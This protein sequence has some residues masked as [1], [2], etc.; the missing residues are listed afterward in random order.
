MF[1][2]TNPAH[3][4]EPVHAMAAPHPRRAKATKPGGR[5]TK[6]ATVQAAM[7]RPIRAKRQ[8]TTVSYSPAIDNAATREHRTLND[9]HECGDSNGSASHPPESTPP[10]I[11]HTWLPM[12]PEHALVLQRYLIE[13]QIAAQTMTEMKSMTKNPLTRP[14][15]IL[16][17]AY[18]P[19]LFRLSSLPHVRM[20]RTESQKPE[21]GKWR[22]ERKVEI[23]QVEPYRVPPSWMAG[24]SWTGNV[25]RR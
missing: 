12:A 1:D 3:P 4:E 7:K 20:T 21:I 2:E 17:D 15:R 10:A 5:A 8:R 13:E 22:E 18:E 25:K 6:Q 19:W 14:G 24:P 23:Y 9:H 16:S 11:I